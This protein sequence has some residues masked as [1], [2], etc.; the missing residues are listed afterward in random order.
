MK[1][2]I[3]QLF[4]ISSNLCFAQKDTLFIDDN[5]NKCMKA[6]ALYYR[7]ITK[8]GT[9]FLEKDMFINTAIPQTI[10]I[11]DSVE[12]I[13]KNGKCMTYYRSGA[14]ES[15]GDYLKDGKTGRWIIWDED[16]KD[17]TIVVYG[18]PRLGISKFERISKNQPYNNGDSIA[19]LI[20][21]MPQFDGGEQAMM[22]FIQKNIQY[23]QAEKAAGISGTCYITFVV[24]KDGSLSNMKML[25]GV[26]GGPGC[27]TEALR[28]LQIMPKWKPGKLNGKNIRVRYNLPIKYSLRS[29]W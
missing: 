17:S 3:F 27:D 19:T 1:K 28:V 26:K 21:V 10:A 23:P 11:C 4:I 14:K 20:E 18:D 12:R 2:I 16:G 15:E 6:T 5:G 25:R 9:Q 7:V 24:E 22:G 29:N 8:Q 13:R